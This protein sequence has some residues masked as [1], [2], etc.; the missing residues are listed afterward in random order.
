[1]RKHKEIEITEEDLKL[2]HGD[3]YKLFREKIIPNCNCTKCN[4][5]FRS[6]IVNYKIFLNDLKDIILKGF[7]AKCGNTVNRY[8]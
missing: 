2:I 5:H 6:T 7:C 8:L 1:M 3:D 4:S